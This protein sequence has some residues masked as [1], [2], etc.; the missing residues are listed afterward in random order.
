[1]SLI[2]WGFSKLKP[3]VVVPALWR[4]AASLIGLATVACI[5]LSKSIQPYPSTPMGLLASIARH[6]NLAST[7][8]WLSH[9]EEWLATQPVHQLAW[10][11]AVGAVC[12]GLHWAARYRVNSI[13][14]L[15]VSLTWIGLGALREVG[16]PAWGILL[17][18]AA[19]ALTV[20]EWQ[21]IR[22]GS[23]YHRLR[24]RLNYITIHVLGS[25]MDALQLLG[26]VLIRGPVA[27][28]WQWLIINPRAEFWLRT[29]ED[30]DDVAEVQPRDRTYAMF[31]P[32]ELAELV[33]RDRI[34][35]YEET[36]RLL[37][38]SSHLEWGLG[39]GR[40][41]TENPPEN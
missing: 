41:N 25:L 32:R 11:L 38:R 37:K 34:W 40:N 20:A 5:P 4:A 14:N 27:L 7:E 19:I 13:E 15:H 29:D 1:M 28:G 35:T 12:S 9:A 6:A 39:T 26:S 10:L 36:W 33:R 31:A 21:V 30:D 18:A 8:R 2:E 16:C 23:R 3:E 24:D 22:F 17:I